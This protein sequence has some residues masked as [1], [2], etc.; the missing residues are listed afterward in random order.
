MNWFKM[1]GHLSVQ[2]NEFHLDRI[3]NMET[4]N[5]GPS[6]DGRIQERLIS[7]AG[8]RDG[9]ESAVLENNLMA[10]LQT[11]KSSLYLLLFLFRCPCQFG[12]HHRGNLLQSFGRQLA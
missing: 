10:S 2:R 9:H 8:Y 6:Q 4:D 12:C 3:N 1:V 5:I 11:V 7:S